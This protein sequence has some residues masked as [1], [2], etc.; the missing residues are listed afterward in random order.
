MDDTLLASHEEKRLI[1]SGGQ[2]IHNLSVSGM[3]RGCVCVRD[4][5]VIHANDE[6][7][8]NVVTVAIEKYLH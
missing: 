1:H 5:L 8:L 3:W 7:W 6:F 2:K 4:L